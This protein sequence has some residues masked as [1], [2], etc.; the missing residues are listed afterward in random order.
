[1]AQKKTAQKNLKTI[2]KAS[3]LISLGGLLMANKE[4][5]QQPAS[6]G[7]QLKKNVRILGVEASSFLDNGGFKFS[8]VA[9]GNFSG[10]LYESNYFNER[11]IY[12]N[13]KTNPTTSGS[14]GIQKAVAFQ[15]KMNDDTL[16]QLKQWY[17]NLKSSDLGLQSEAACLIGR[18]QHFLHV[19]INSLE[20]HSG[21]GLTL[22]FSPNG[23][24]L[25]VTGSVSID[26]MQMNGSAMAMDPWSTET[27]GA[28]ND[29]F[30]KKD[31]KFQLGVPLG[32]FNFGLNF[33]RTTGME[34]TVIG[35]LRKLVTGLA[36]QLLKKDMQKWSTRVV[37]SRDNKVTLLGGDELNIK[38]G[39]EFEVVNEVY[40]WMGEPCGDGSVM[41]GST[42]VTQKPWI[43]KVYSVGKQMSI[44]DVISPV[45]ENQTISVG[46]LVRVHKLVSDQATSSDNTKTK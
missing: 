8:E 2:L 9:K 27:V 25:P 45:D 42:P 31:I 4:C 28:H 46:A 16:V 6:S 21:G 33:Y 1:M 3:V 44:A 11:N 24:T 32:A 7:R 39:D 12:P 41:I 17:P 13:W 40:D 35:T 22:G 43:V 20:A 34:E 15:Q 26:R 23:V 18:P 36:D 19:K 37:L 14:T 5:Q 10:I 30:M 38:V 29:N